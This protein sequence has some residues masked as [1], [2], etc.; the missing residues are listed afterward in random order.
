M[1]KDIDFVPVYDKD[2]L[3]KIL[4]HENLGESMS[5]TGYNLDDPPMEDWTYVAILDGEELI[6]LAAAQIF[7]NTQLIWHFGIRRKYWQHGSEKYGQNILKRLNFLN[8]N[9]S[10]LTLVPLH[11]KLALAYAKRVGFKEIGKSKHYTILEF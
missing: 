4:H 3:L 7:S 8:K 9:L 5:D 1:Q 11:K 2:I 6:G 10:H